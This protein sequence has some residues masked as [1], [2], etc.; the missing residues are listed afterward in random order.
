VIVRLLLFASAREAAGRSRDEFELA[1]GAP[2]ERLL[3][4]AVDRYGEPFAQV[5]TTARVWINGDEPKADRATALGDDDEIAVLPPVSGGA[6]GGSRAIA[7]V[8]ARP[9]DLALL[10]FDR[11]CASTSRLRSCGACSSRPS[12][13]HC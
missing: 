6:G 5:L 4:D 10:A 11:S 1:S 2:L 9:S 12:Q 7:A 13:S 8:L 3:A